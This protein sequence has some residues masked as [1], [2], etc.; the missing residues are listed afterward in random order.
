MCAA[1]ANMVTRSA[2]GPHSESSNITYGGV[3][4]THASLRSY[5]LHS[6][7]VRCGET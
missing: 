3:N 4:F 7:S 5:V 1:E 6:A 2:A